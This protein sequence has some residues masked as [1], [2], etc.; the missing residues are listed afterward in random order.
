MF[1]TTLTLGRICHF[2]MHVDVMLLTL[3][4]S[5][6]QVRLFLS[7]SI[8]KIIIIIRSEQEAWN[9]LRGNAGYIMRPTLIAHRLSFQH[10]Q[11]R[12][13]SETKFDETARNHRHRQIMTSVINQSEFQLIYLLMRS[14]IFCSAMNALSFLTSLIVDL[15][16]FLY[17]C[18]SFCFSAATLSFGTFFFPASKLQLS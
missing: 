4:V 1:V 10:H 15:S 13:G 17:C 11:K 6:N 5:K 14:L 7:L 3:Q 16:S 12:I 8:P 9:V 2:L 18:F